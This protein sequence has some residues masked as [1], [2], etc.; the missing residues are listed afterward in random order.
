MQR[1]QMEMQEQQVQAQQQAAEAQQAQVQADMEMKQ[2]ELQTKVQV[3]E[4]DANALLESTRMK[5]EGGQETQD[6]RQQHDAKMAMLNSSNEM[7]KKRNEQR[8]MSE[9]ET[10]DSNNS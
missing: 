4:I 8:I 6:F 1:Q 7:D 9:K 5:I 3:A 10:S 2:A